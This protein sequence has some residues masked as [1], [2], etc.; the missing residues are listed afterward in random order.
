MKCGTWTLIHVLHFPNLWGSITNK[1]YV[2][3]GNLYF[4]FAANYA[5]F[6]VDHQLGIWDENG[7]DLGRVQPDHDPNSKNLSLI[8]FW[9]WPKSDAKF[10]W[11]ENVRPTAINVLIYSCEP[12]IHV[13]HMC[14]GFE[15][16]GVNHE[17]LPSVDRDHLPGDRIQIGLYVSPSLTR[18]RECQT[19]FGIFLGW[20]GRVSIVTLQVVPWMC[21]EFFSIPQTIMGNGRDHLIRF[22]LLLIRSMS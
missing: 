1:R 22:G 8:G 15:Y 18:T 6:D 7:L 9:G 2:E 10:N 17:I 20:V 5:F 14:R 21:L 11:V 19:P 3:S 13:N 12:S 4:I 16:L